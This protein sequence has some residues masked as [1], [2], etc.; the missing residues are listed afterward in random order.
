MVRATTSYT[1]R[2]GTTSAERVSG[3]ICVAFSIVY[4]GELLAVYGTI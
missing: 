1:V 3:K 4:M 2:A